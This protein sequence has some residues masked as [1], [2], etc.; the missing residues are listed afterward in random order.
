MHDLTFLVLIGTVLSIVGIVFYIFY[1]NKT[2]SLKKKGKT[3]PTQPQFTTNVPPSNR[4][5]YKP[6]PQGIPSGRRVFRTNK[7]K[8]KEYVVNETGLPL[9]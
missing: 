4:I 6:I 5:F 9:P 7:G 1:Q 2:S 3:S 8:L